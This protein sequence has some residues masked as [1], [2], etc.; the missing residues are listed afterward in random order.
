MALFQPADAAEARDM[1]ASACAD[2]QTL[3]IVAGGTKRALGRAVRTAH[4]LDVSR[5][6]GIIDYD[7]AELVLTAHAATPMPEI[8]ALLASEHQMLAFEPP[9]WRALLGSDG[10]PTLGGVVA[11]N[12][13]G[14]RRVR[15]GAP[16]DHLLG[17]SAINGRGELWKSGGR[18]VKNV[19][20]YDMCKL[21]AGAY[22]TLSV[23]TEVSVR[24]VPRPDT[25]CSVIVQDLTDNDANA[26]MSQALN[27]QH[28]VSGA[29]HLPGDI[30]GRSKV[31]SVA[32]SKYGV[33]VLRLEGHAPSVA[34]RVQALESLFAGSTRLDAADSALL[35]EEIGAVAPLMPWPFMW[36]ICATPSLAPQ[37]VRNVREREDFLSVFYDWGGGLVWMS[38]APHTVQ[39]DAG[40]ELVRT[41]IG[42]SGGHA[43]LVLA[44]EDLRTRVEVFQPQSAALAALSLR[45]KN[46]FD[47]DRILNPGRMWAGV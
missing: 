46:S 43:T 7:P 38:L 36:R 13:A 27:S 26:A 30:A 3:E 45:V 34:F 25:S 10:V 21:Q 11:C 14:P 19:T 23:L 47:P 9:D 32:G 4:T 20:G 29:A 12:L 33:T 16:R 1:V 39:T 6:A 2:G 8:E 37:I 42:S 15:A 35:W 22:G 31:I 24:V 28:D 18:V 40:E 41:A 44:P 5:L 17:F